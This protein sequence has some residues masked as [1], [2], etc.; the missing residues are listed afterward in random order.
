M[1]RL[2]GKRQ[3]AEASRL[4]R[5]DLGADAGCKALSL[6]PQGIRC[7][8]RRPSQI[9]AVLERGSCCMVSECISG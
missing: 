4:I 9:A 8:L 2:A 6:S 5:L 1:I 3:Q 7:K